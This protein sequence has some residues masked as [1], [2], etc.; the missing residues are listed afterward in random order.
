M[1]DGSYQ[2]PVGQNRA[3]NVQ[4]RFCTAEA[5]KFFSQ[6]LYGISATDPPTYLLAI[7]LMGIVAFA[8]CL[9]PVRR[10]ISVDPVRALRTE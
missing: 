9:V 10:A 4:R 2:L 3:I 8:A 1:F 6:I 7:G 5:G